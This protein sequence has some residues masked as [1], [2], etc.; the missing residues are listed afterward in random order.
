MAK[1]DPAIYVNVSL[2]DR[3]FSR[4]GIPITGITFGDHTASMVFNPA[5]T[6]ISV[7]S[8]DDPK[9]GVMKAKAAS[10]VD[11]LGIHADSTALYW[12]GDASISALGTRDQALY[13]PPHVQAPLTH[14]VAQEII[15]SGGHPNNV[16]DSYQ[17]A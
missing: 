8:A 16:A 2:P 10:H 5:I 4:A 15:N 3:N 7:R 14:T 1:N 9:S 12:A 13:T 11:T 17:T 6:F